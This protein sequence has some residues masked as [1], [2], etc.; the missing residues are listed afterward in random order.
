MEIFDDLKQLSNFTIIDDSY[1]YN[2][3]ICTEH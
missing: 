3:A 1:N 2:S